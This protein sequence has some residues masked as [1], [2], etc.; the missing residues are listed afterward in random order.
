MTGLLII[1]WPYVLVGILIL[2]LWI[3]AASK[4][5]DAAELKGYNSKSEH[6]FAICFCFGIIGCLYVVA[7]PD[8]HLQKLLKDFL[9]DNKHESVERAEKKE[10]KEIKHNSNL[11]AICKNIPGIEL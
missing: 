6:I 5:C 7:L 10:K 9:D 2:I 8:L 1:Y 4:M 11:E 3:F